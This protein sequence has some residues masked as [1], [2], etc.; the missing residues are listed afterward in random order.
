M[1][2]FVK[3]NNDLINEIY[4]CKEQI[5][6]LNERI[7]KGNNNLINLK[8]EKNE[9]E[10]LIIKREEKLNIFFE[11]LNIFEEIIKKRTKLLKE[12]ELYSKELIK[13]VEEQKETIKE[14]E[15]KNKINNENYTS[16]N[17]YN[18]SIIGVNDR[19][20]NIYN[21]QFNEDKINNNIDENN[22]NI[23]LPYLYNNSDKQDKNENLISSNIDIEEKNKIKFNE[24]KNLV[25][26]LYNNASN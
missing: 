25:D 10:E 12:N 13:I 19:Y 22:N 24:F 7:E 17:Y 3:K 6:Q 15:N 1:E 26:D 16:S 18:K 11:K 8:K 20:N 9:M 23:V 5:N 4:S 2:P 14:L 21:N